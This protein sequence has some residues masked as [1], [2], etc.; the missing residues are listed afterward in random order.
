MAEEEQQTLVRVRSI[1]C[2]RSVCL[3]LYPEC[4]VVG[5]GMDGDD[6]APARFEVQ[7]RRQAVD[8]FSVG[9]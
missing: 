4:R 2:F 7:R 3:C 9:K 6:L 8:L 5:V 1:Q